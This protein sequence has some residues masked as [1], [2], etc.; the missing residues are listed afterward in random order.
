VIGYY[1]HRRSEV[2]AY[3]SRRRQEA[4][5]LRR[6]TA[7]GFDPIDIRARLLARRAAGIR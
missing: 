1:L 4:E 6:N 3:L 7:T 5:E 2:D